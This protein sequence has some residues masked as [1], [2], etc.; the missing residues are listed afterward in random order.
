[1]HS[2]FFWQEGS[3]AVL[4][5]CHSMLLVAHKIIPYFITWCGFCAKSGA[6]I[7]W[8]HKLNQNKQDIYVYIF[9]FQMRPSPQ[10]KWGNWPRSA[11]C[12]YLWFQW[13]PRGFS[14][15]TTLMCMKKLIQSQTGQDRRCFSIIIIAS[16]LQEAPLNSW[17][18][19]NLDAQKDCDQILCS[20]IFS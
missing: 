18:G 14:I 15:I 1:M 12:D 13:T 9:V 11:H 6:N 3:I 7:H 8:A 2:F 16:E 17:T 10:C 5:F 20:V 4:E 19:L